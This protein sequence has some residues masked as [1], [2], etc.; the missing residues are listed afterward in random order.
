MSRSAES[1]VHQMRGSCRACGGR[2]LWR[3]LAL[4][5]TPLANAFL[6]SPD[7]FAFEPRYPLDVY[8]CRTCSLV[9]LVDLIDPEVLFRHYVYVTGTSETIAAHNRRYTGNLVDQLHLGDNDLVVEVASNDG[10]LLKCFQPYGVRTLGVEPATNIAEMARAAGI[11]TV[12]CFFNGA[13]AGRIR[14]A[15][16]PARVVIA[17]N[18]LAHVDDP[19]DFLAGGKTLL[20]E[21]GRV[22]IEVP[23]LRDLLDRLEYD[24]I[25]HEHL[26]YF[27]VS[28]LVRLCDAVGLSVLRM[29]HVPVHGGSLR[30]HGGAR[31]ECGPHAGD[32][33]A[34]ADEERR[35]G[36]S[37]PAR[38]ERFAAEVSASRRAL[39]A[40]L[41]SLRSEGKTIAAYGA[42]AKG[43]TLLNYCGID[44]RLVS[45]T[46]DQ[47]P[48]K[49]GQY[50]PGMHIP[51]LPVATLLEHQPDFV[52]ILA[53]NLAEEIMRQQ[54]EYRRRGGRFI[55]PVPVARVV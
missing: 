36:L 23:Y 22:V 51:V 30:M 6:A 32:V 7:A 44:A 33:L 10:S 12:A 9:Q 1:S 52:L 27:S 45:Y 48:L 16:G 31:D 25:Y 34:W 46:V 47:N 37:D 54:Q 35:L 15:H 20:T 14:E 39:L 18:V 49:V 42:P 28:T 4:G 24:T 41:R 55:L 43:N 53:W 50:T 40:L 21:Q 38:Y 11:Q 19:Q 13:A 2:D 3:F 29:E 17:N 8:F 26:C 5:P